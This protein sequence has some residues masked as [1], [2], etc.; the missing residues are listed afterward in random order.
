MVQG[1]ARTA[2]KV[3][4]LMQVVD[5]KQDQIEEQGV[6]EVLTEEVARVGLECKG[7]QLRAEDLHRHLLDSARRIQHPPGPGS[8]QSHCSP[9]RNEKEA[10]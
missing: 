3:Q 7:Q 10:S 1:A 2:T 5:R 8:R 9:G 4:R 6:V